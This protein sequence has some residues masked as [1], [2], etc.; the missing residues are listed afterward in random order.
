MLA[1]YLTEKSLFNVHSNFEQVFYTD[2]SVC[3][4][5]M[6]DHDSI[7]VKPIKSEDNNIKHLPF[8]IQSIKF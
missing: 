8:G 3:I 4:Q 7:S 6:H 5:S 2:E 1:Q